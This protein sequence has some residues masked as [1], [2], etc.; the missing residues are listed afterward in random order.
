MPK[1]GVCTSTK[2]DYNCAFSNYDFGFAIYNGGLRH[3]SDKAGADYGIKIKPT[4]LIEVILNMNEGTLEFSIDGINYG[5]AFKSEKLKKGPIY[6]AVSLLHDCVCTLI[7][8]Q[9]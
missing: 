9:I 4:N 3:N 6:P 7:N 1:I 2:F 5:V 8:K